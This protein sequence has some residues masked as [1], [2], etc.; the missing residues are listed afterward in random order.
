MTGWRGG[1]IE[2]YHVSVFSGP[3]GVD[4]TRIR[5]LLKCEAGVTGEL[6]FKIGSAPVD[7]PQYH[8]TTKKFLFE[9]P[10]TDYPAII[11]VLRNEKP[12]RFF[13]AQEGG[14]VILQT[15]DEP[16]GEGE[17]T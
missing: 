12:L 14:A 9:L 6:H 15:G 11:D 8:G 5:V 7:P 1:F 4:G 10:L 17:N 13:V 2:S 16:V 3:N